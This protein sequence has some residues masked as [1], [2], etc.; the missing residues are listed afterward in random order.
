[1]GAQG[2]GWAAPG[3]AGGSEDRGPQRAPRPWAANALG[4]PRPQP[5]RKPHL[6]LAPG[7]PPRSEPPPAFQ[8]LSGGSEDRGPQRAPRPWAANAL[9][10]PRPQ[11]HRKPHLPLA[12]GTPPRS[13]PPPA[14]Q[15]LSGGSEDRGPQR[16]PRPW[17]ANALGS[18]RPQPHRK[19]HLPLA[20]GT[21]PRSEPPPAFQPLSGGSED[22]GPQRAPR[23]WAANALGSPRP[24]PHRKPH[25]P[26]APGTPPR[27]EPPPA[28]QPLSGGS[29]DRGPQRA[30]RPWAANAL[31][32]P[33]PQPHRK[34]HLPLAPGT[35]PRSEP[36][37]AFQPL[38][39]GSEDRGPQRA[40]RPWAA[41][42]LGSPRPQ[43]HRKPHLPLAPG[44]PP[45]SEPPPAFQ[46][47]SGG[48]EDR[49]PQRAPRPWA[50][51][52]LGSPRPQPH[53]KPHLPLAPGTPPRS[54]PPPAF[55]PLSG[56]SEDRGPQR[57]PRP[58]AANALG[59]PRPQPHRKPHLPLAPGTPPRSEPPPAFQPLSGGSEDRGPQR[60]PRPWAANALGSPRPQPHRKPHLPLAPGTPPRSEPPPAFQPL[61]GGSEDRGPQRAPR[62]WAANALGSP[63][64]QPH[65]KPHLP[66][67]PGTPPR[68]EPPPAFQPLSGGSEDRGPQRAPRPWAAN[69]LGSPRPQPHRKPHLPLAPGTPPRSE[70]PPAFQPLS[71][72][73]ED[74]GPQRAPRPWAANALGSPRPQPHRKPHLPLAPGT[75]PRSEPPPAFQPLSGGSEDRGPQRAPRPWAANA[76]GSP[77]PQPHRKPHL[78]LAPGT[79]PRSEPPP[80]FQPLS[81]GSED[82]GPQRAPRPW[83][84]NALGSPRPQPH[85]KPHLPLAPGTPPRSEP[86]PAF[87]P[88]SGGSEDR[89]PQRAPRPWAANALGSPRPQ[90]HRKPHLP[91]A[92]GTPPRSEPPPAFQPLSGGSED[93][94]PQRAP[95]PWAAN[96]LGSPRPQP[97]RKPHLPLAPGTPPRSEPPPAFQPLSGGSEDRGPQRAPRPWAAN[98][99]GSP[100][101]QPHRKPH[102]P[103]APGTPPRS[104]PPPAFQ[105]LSGGSEDRGPQRA[106]RP[107]AA[108]ALGSPRPQPHRKPHLPLAPG[109]PPRSEPPPAFQPL[110]GGSEDRGPQRA[111]RPWAANALGSPRP[112]P[113]RKPHLPLAPGTP[114]RSEPP[115]AFQPLSGGSEDRGPQR[116]PRP[117][118]ANALGSPRPQPHRKPHLPL[119]PGTPPRSEPPPAFQPLSG[120][121]EDRGPQRAPRPWAANALGSPRPQ[122]HRKPHLPLAPGTPPR[123]E[124]PPA[125]QPLS[126]GSEDRGPQRAPRPWAANALGSPRPQPHRKPHLPLAPGTPPRSEPPPA[127]QPLSGG[128]EDRGPQ[129]AP[130][131]WAANALGSPRPQPHRKPHLPLAPGTPPRSEPPPAFQPLSGG[132]EDR[133]PQ[134][135]PR[136]WAANALGSP[137]PQPHRKPHLPLAP[138]TP[139]RSEPPPAFQ[140]LSG[141]SED[142]G[143][144]RAPRPW[145]ANALGSPRPQ[146]HRKPH[147]PLAPGTPP[148]SEPPPAFQPLSGGSED[149]GP[150]RAPRPWAANA[151]GSPRPQPH[152]KPHLPLAPGT[153]PR[154]EPP[155]AFQPL[156]GGSEDR[157]PQRAPRPWAANAL[158]SPRP[159]PH[160]KPHLPL[161]P[162][163]PPRSEPPPAFQPL[164]GGSEDRGPQRAPRPWA[165]NALG[166]PRPQPHRKP[167]LPLAPGTPPRS[168]PPPA[169]QPLSGGSEDRGPQRAPRPWAANALGSPRPQ[170]HRKPHLPLAPGTPPRSE[171]PPA[172]Q[173]LSGGSEDRGPQRAPRPWA[174]NALGSPRPQPHRKPHLP[175]A[176][177][178]P[179]RSEPPPAFQPLSGGSEDRGPQRAPRPWAANA[180]GSPRPQ[181]HRKPH[182]PLAPGTPPRSE[183]P[184]AF[185]PLS[186]GSEDRGPQRAPRPWAANAL[187]SPRPQPH[188]KPHL[189]LAPGTPPRSEPPPAFQ[190][191]SGGSEDRGPQRAPRPWAANALGSP[192]PQ[193]HRKPHLPLAPGTPPR[194]EPPPAFQ[195]LSGGSEDR[196]PQRAPRPWAANALGSPRPQPHRK[197]HLPLAPGTPPRS[198]PPP[199]FQPLSGGS[200]DRGPQRAPRPWAANALG[201][202]RPQPHRKPH[203]PLAPGTPP[204]SEP[205]PA[206]QPLSGGS[207]DRGPQRAPRPWAANALGSPRPQ[208][209]RKPH[210]PLA[211]GTPPRS[212]PPPAFQPLSGGS[213]DRGPQRAPRPWAANAL[214]SPRPQPHRKPHLPLAPGTP[215]RSEPPPA[216]QPLSG[217]S[218]DRGPQR[219]PRPWAAN[220]LGSP[221]PQPHRKPHL[222][223]APGTPPRSEPPPAF[224]P[225]SGGSE[226]RGPQRAP[227]PWAANAL[228]SPRPQPH[229]KPHLPLAPGT[230]PR[231]EPPPA[232]QPLSGGSEDRGPQRAPRPWAAN[233]LGSPRPQPHRKPHLPLAPG[234]P[235][236]SEPPPAFQPLSG[237]SEDRGPQRAPRPWAANALGSPR[238][239]PHRKPHLPL[240]PGTPPRSEPPPAFQPLSGGSEDRGPQRAPR[241]WAANALGSPRPQPHRKPH[242]PLAPGTPP[243]SEPPP[244]FQPLSGGSEDRGP[245]RAPRPWAAN[246]LGSPRPQPHRKPHLPL[247]PGTP[248]RSEP[249]P[250]FQ[251][252]SGGSEDRGP[253]R[254]PR[255]WA[256]NALGSPRPQPHRKPHLPLA[257]GTPPRSEPPPAF[258]PLSGGSED[259]GPQRAPRPWAANALGS[260]RPQPHRK[261]HLPLAPGTPP[262][263]EPPPAFQ[264]L[265]GGSE[266]RGPQRA[267]RPWAANALGSPRPQPH[268]KPHLPL[269]PGTP[270]RSEPPPAFQP[271]SG[272]SEDRGPQRA[273]R[274]WAANALGSPRP[275]PHRKPHLPLAP[276]T[277]PR[278][279]PP[280]A[281]QPLSGG[282]EDRGP[283]RAPRPWAAN[284]LGSPRPQPH[285]KPHLPLAPGTPPRSE[286]P[287]AFQPLSG[288]SEDRGPQRAP[289]PWAANALGSPRP[290]PHRKPHLPLAPGTPP[291]SEPPPAF[292][293]LSGG[294]EDR[295]PQR[296]PRPWAANALGSPRPQPHRKPH[297]PLAPGTPP[298]SEP[299][300][301]FQPLSGG[302]EDR[303]PQRAPRPWAANAL[304]SPRPQPH[305]KPHLPLAPG[306]PPRSE[307]PPAFQPLSGGSEDRGPQ[308]APRPWAANALGSPRPQPHRKPHLPL[309]PGTPPRSEPPP[310]FQPLSGGSEDRGPQRAPRPWAAN[311]LGSP[312]PQP[313]RKPHLPL[314]PGTPPRSEPPPAFQPLSGGSEDRGPQ[315]APR[316]WAANALGSPRPQ[317]H[318]KPHLPLAPGTPPRSEPPPAFQP[319][320]GGSEDRGPQRAP[321]PWAANAL[322]SPRPQPH[323]KPHLPLAPGTPP[324]SEPP[325]AFQPLSGGSEDRGPQRAPRPWAANALGSPRPQPHRKPH[326]PLAPGTPPRSEPPPAFQPLSG[327]SEDRGPQRAPRPWAANALGSPRP[328]PHRKPHL[329]LAP[330]TPP[331]SEPP[332]AFQPL[333]GG[334]EDRGPQRAPRPWAANALGS[335]RPQPHRKPHLPLAPGTPPRSEPP[336]AF[337]PLS[338]GSEDRGP[339]RAPR[340]W[341]ANALGSPRPQPHRKPHLPL[342][343]GTPPRSEPPPAFQPLS[344]GSEDRGPQRAPRPWA[345]NAL[346]SPRPQPHRKPHLPLAPGTPPRSEPP[347][348]FQPLSGGSEDRGPQR[349]PRPWAANALGSPRPQPHRKPHLPLAPGTPPRSEPPPAFQPLSGGSEDRGP[350][351]APRPWAANAL[352][353][354]RPQPHRKPH[355]PLAPGTPPRSEPPPAFQPLSG[356]SEDRGPQRAPRPWA[357]NALGSPRPQPHRKPHLPLAPGTP[358]RSEPPPAFQPLSGG[359]EDRGPQRA[360]RPWAANALGS[361]RPQPHRKPHLP[362]APGTPP[363]SEPPPAFQPLSGGSE[364]RGPQRAP[365]PW[366]A[367]ALGSP[368]PQPHRKPHLPLAPGTPPRSEPPPAFQPL[369]GGSEDRGPQRAPRPWAANALGSPRPQPH[370][371]PHL[372]LAPGTPP[373]SEPPPAFQPLSGGSEDRGPQRA[374][375]PWA[376]N[377]LGSPR[378]QPHRKPH[379]PLAPGTPPRS[380]PPPAFQP[381]SGG[382][383]DRG[384]QRAPRP[385]AANALGSPRPQPHRKPHLPLAPGTPP[386]SE[387]PPAFQPLSGGSEDRGPQRAPRPWAANALGSPRPQPHRKPH[388][389]LAPGTPPRSEP[390]PAFQPLSGGS[391]DRGPQ[392]A[393]RPWAANALGS[394]RPQPHR[395]PHLPLAP[396]TPPRS[397]PPPAFQPLSGGSEDRGP[398][399][400]P[401]PWAANALGSPRPQPHR[402]P[403]LPLAPGTPPRSE[404][405]P[406]FQPLSGGSED[407]GPQRA[408]R[409][410]A[411]NALGSP[412]PQPHRKPHLPLAPGTPPRSE[413]PP[414]FQPLSG[415]SEDRGPQ[416]A[417]RPWAANALGSPR[418][419]PH[420][421]PHLPLAPGTPPRSEPPPAF[422]PLSG[423]SED[424][425]PQR[426]PRPWAAN[427]LGSPRP[428]PHRKPHLPLAPGTP[429]RSEPPPAFQPLSGGSEDRGPQRAPR[430]WAANALGSPRPQ[431]HRKPHLPLAPGTPPRSEPP[432]AFQPLSGGSEDR[433]PQRAPRPWAAN[434][435]GSPRPQPHR[436]PHLPL[437]PGTPPRSEP[438]PAFQPLSG[439]SEDR[440]PQRAPRPWAANALEEAHP[441]GCSRSRKPCGPPGRAG[442]VLAVGGGAG[443]GRGAACAGSRAAGSP[444]A[445][446][447]AQV[448]RALRAELESCGRRLAR[449]AGGSE[450]RGPQRAPRPWAANALGSPRP[451]PHRKPHLPLAPGTPPRSEPPPAFQPLS[452]GSEDRGPQR[453]PRPWAANA[454]GSPR[455]QPHRKPHLPLAPGTPP[456]SEPPPAFQPLSGGSEDRGPQRAPRPWAANALGSP[457]PQPHRK[458]HL[459]LAPG[460]PPRS[461][462]PPAFQPLSGGSE[463]R[464][465][466]RAPRPWAAN[467]LGSPRPQPHRKPHLPL[468]PGTPPRSEPPP[469]FQPLS[470][471]SEDRG[472]QR[473]GPRPWAANALGSPRPQPHRKPHL[474]LAPGTPP[475]SEPPPAFQPLS[476]GSEDRG[477]Q[478]APRPWAANA[479]GSP[480]P[481]PHRKPH[482]PL[483]PGTPPRSEPPPAFQPLSGGSE[484]RGPQRAPRPWAANALGSPRPQPH[485]KPHLPLA[486]GTPPRSEP[487]PAFQPLSG[488]SEDRGPQRAPRPWA[489]NA[490]GSPRP[491]PHRKPHLPLA[492][493]TP[494]RSEPPPAFQPLSGGSEDRGPQ[495][496]PRPWAANALGSPRPQ[497]HRKPHL[498]LAPGTPPRSEPPPA[499][500]P[501]SGGSEDRGPQ[502]APRP[503]AANAL[504]SPRPQ[505]HRKPHLPLAPGTPPRSEPPP[506]FQPL[507]GGSEDRGPQR[508]PRPWAANALGSPRPQPHR[509][510]HL[511]LAPGTPPR[512]EPPPAFQPLSGGSE[513]RG[514][515]RAPRP[516][517]ANALGSPRPQPH[518]KPHL[519]LAPGTPP[520]SEPPPAFQPLSGGSEDRGPQRA[521][522]PWAANALGSPRPQPHRKPHLPLAPGTP[523]RSEPPPAFQ[524]LSGGSED[525][526][527]QRAPRPWAANALGSPR[528]QPH[529]KPHLPLAP[530]TPPRSEPPPAFQPLSGGSEDRGPQRAPRPWAAN[531]L[532]S[533]RPQPHRK[534]HLPL[535]PG[536]PPRSEPPPAFQPLSGGSEDRGPQ[537][538]PR[539]WAANALGSPRPQPH[540][541]PHLPLAPGTPPRSEP[542]P[543]FQPLSGGSEDRGPQRAPRPWAANALGSPR[544]QPHRKPHLPLAPGTPPRSEPPPAFQPLSGGSEDRG[545]QR[546][547]RP[548]AANA[549]GS[550]RPQPHRKPHLPLAPGTPPRSEP[551][552]AFQPLSGGSEDR[553]PQRAPRP[554]A[555]NA[556][557]SPRP[558]PHRKPH[559]PLAPGTPPRSEPP[560]AFQPLSGGS[561][562]RGPQRAPRPWAANAL[563]SPRP[564]PHRK[565]HLPLAP[566]TPP[567][568]EPPPAFQPLSGGSEDRGPQR[569][570]RPWAANAL[571]SPR[572]QPHRKPHLPLAPG[573]P[574]RSE[575]PPA[576]Q[577]LSGGSE[578]RG[579]QRAPR[580]WAANALGSPRPQPH[581]KPHLP[582]AP[583]TPPR[584]EPP[585]AFQPLSGGSEDRGPQRAP[586]PWAA[587]ALGSPRPQ[588][589]RKPHL[590]LAPGTPPRSEPP[591]AFQPLSGGS[592][593]RGPQRAPR[594]WAA[595][596]LGSPRP[597]PHRKPHLPLAPGT[598]P[599]SEPPPAFQPLSGGSEDRGPQRAPR[600]W[601]ANALGS[602]R[603][604]PHRKPHLPLAPGTP[605]R[606]EPPP[607]FQPLSGGSED[608]GPQRAPR[609]WAANALG[610]PRPQ[611]HR[612]PHLP[613]APGTPP[614]SE[615]PPAF[616]PLSGGSEDRGPQRAPRPWAANALGSPRPQPHRKPHLPLAPGTPPRSEPPP[617]FQP[618]SG[619]S[620]DR[621]PQRAPRP[622]AA[623]ALGS[624]R[625]QPHRKPHLPLAPGT[626][627]RS[628]PPPAFQPLSGGSEDRG[629]QRA[630]RPWA[631]NALGSPRPQPHRKPHLPLAPGTPPRSEPPPAFQPLSGGSEDRGPQRAPRPWA[632][633]AL[634]SPRPQPHRKPHLP[635]APG[636]PPRSEP[637][638]AFQPLSGGSED[639]GPQRAP[640]PWA[641][642][643]LGSPRPQPHRKPHL[644]LAPGTPPRSEPP[645]A[646][647]PLS[648]GS[649]DRGP[650]RAP[651]P[652]AANALGSPRPQPHRKPHLPLAPGTPPRSEPPPAFQPLSGGS[653]D[654]GPQR[655]PR[656]WAANALGSPRPQPHRKPHLPLAP[657]TPPRSEPP[658]AFQPLSGGSEDRGPQRAPRPW[659]ANA[660]GS[661]RPQPHRKPHLPLAPGTPPRSEPPPAFQPLSGGSEDRGPQ[662]A[663]RPWAANALGSPRPQPHRKPHLPLAPGTPPRSEPPPAF[664]PLSGGSEDRGPQRAPRPWA[665]NALGSP[666]PQPHRK[667]HLPLAPG[668]PPRSEPPP[669]FQPLSGGS[670]DRGPQRAPRPWAANALG[671]PRPQPHRKPHLP[672]APGTPPR[673]EPPPAFQPLSG[674]SEDRGPQRAPRPWAANAL[675]S[676]RPQPHRKPHLPLAPGT[677]PRSEPPPAFQPL[678]GGSE[679]RGPQRAPRPWAA[680]ALGSPRPQPHRKPHLPLAPGTPP[681]SEPPPAFQPL[682]GGSED[683]GPQRAPRPWAANALGS[684]RPQPHRKPHLPLA[685]GTPPR[686]EPPPAFQPLSGGSEDRGP[687]RAPRP[688]AANALGSPRPQPHRKPH[689]PLAPGTP[690]R[691]EPPPAFQPLSGGSE[692]R[693]PQRAPRP[694]AANALGSP[695][696]QPHRKPHLPLAPGTPPRSEPPPAFQPLSGGSE[697]RGPQRAPRPWAAN[698]LGSPRP[699]PHR[700]PHLPLAPGTPP[701]SE[702]PPAFQPL[703]G[704]SEDRGPQRAPRPWAANALGSPRPQP[705]R[706][707]HLPLA[708]GTPPRSEPPPAFQPLSGGSE[709]RGP[710]R[711][712]RPWAANAL[713][714][715]R[716]QPHRKPHLPLAPGTP[717]RSEP[718]PAFQ[719]LSGGSE[720]RGPQ[721]AP[722]PWAANALGSPRPQPHRKPHLPLAPGTPPR[723][724]PPPAFQPLSGGSEDRGPQRA[725]RPWAANALGSPRPQPHRKPHL[726]LAPG[727][728]PR[729]EP[730]PAFQPLS[731][732]SEDRGPQRA[733]RPWAANALGSPRPQPH[734]KP[735][736]PLAPGTPPRSEPP[737]AFQPLSGGSE[738]RGPQRAPRPWAANALGSPRPQPHRKPHLPLAPGTPPRSEPPPAFQPLSGG[739]EDRGPQRAPRP[740]AANALGSPRPQ[741][742][743]KPH[744][745]LAPGTPPRSEPPPAFQPLS[746]G[747]EDRGPQ[748]A[749]RPW[750]ANALG[751]PRP[752]P[753]RKPHLPLAPG[754]PPRSEPPP[755][756]QPLSGGS[757]DRGPQR[758]PRP[759]A[760]NALGSPRPQPHRKPHLPLAPG[761]PP[762]SEPPPAFQPLS[763]GSEDRGPQ[764]APRPWAANALGSPRPQPHRKP[765]LPLAPG[766]PPRSEPPPAFQ[767]LSGG[768]EDRGPQRAPRPW[769]ANAL[770]SPRPQPHRKPHLPLA[771]GTPPRS[772]PPPAFQPLSGGF[773]H[774]AGAGQDG[775]SGPRLGCA[776]TQEA[777]RT[778]GPSGPEA[779]GSERLG[780][781]GPVL[782]GRHGGN[783]GAS[784][785]RGAGLTSSGR[786]RWWLQVG[787]GTAQVPG[788]MG[789]QGHGWAAPGPA[790]GSEDRGPQRAPRPWAANALGSPR[791][792]PH[793]KPHLPL[794][795]GTPPRSEPPPASWPSQP[796]RK[797]HLPLAP[798]TPPR[799]EPPPA[800]QP[801]SG[802]SEDRGPQRAPRPWAANALGSPRPQPHRKPH[803]PLAPGTPPRSEPPPAFQPLSGGSEDRGPQRAPR[804]W[805]ANALGSPRPQPHRKPHLPL[806]PGTPPRSEPPPAFQPLSG[807]S[808]DRGPQRA[809][810]PWA[811]NALGSPRPQPHRKP[812][813]PLAP[814]T[815]PRSE[816]P[817]AFQPLSGGSE[818][819]GP[820]RAPRP[821][822]ANA[823]GSPR[824]QPHR[825]PHLP[826]APGTPPRS[827]PPPAFQPLSASLHLAAERGPKETVRPEECAERQ[828]AQPSSRNPRLRCAGCRKCKPLAGQRETQSH[829]QHLVETYLSAG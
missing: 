148:R 656:P 544:P 717:P 56:G 156:S 260:P 536:T 549:L 257:P 371:K 543:A 2:H 380:E 19:P 681:R 154:S 298:R 795:P 238:P 571:G 562:D 132:S 356:G 761:T 824:P 139:P 372:P 264:P 296:A 542:P 818:D 381:L 346:G 629:P 541:K 706:K 565:P 809:P 265:S 623:N 222:P 704:G 256:A 799:S 557:G 231:S 523:P 532:G 444:V 708:P 39:G 682:S 36:P 695:R 311:A 180:L 433:G 293:P 50:A 41:N 119:A 624:P 603:P 800:F 451:Q 131:P 34:P 138:G 300:P 622:W 720:D 382:S 527:P 535:A 173:P 464:G 284:A 550:P 525:R 261:P 125:F 640:R 529:R 172:F 511:P 784:V 458:P 798:G 447:A 524:P 644:P 370:R 733:P 365:R 697:D 9:G 533:P 495:R 723:S 81:G 712:P 647:Q 496:A 439:G 266:D 216:F 749:P 373:R 438:P 15:P 27:S 756:F 190:P 577:P 601:A 347:P 775:R 537:R 513:D 262:R 65:R 564:Q 398:Q 272:G 475:R 242:L 353:S 760:A 383:E 407:R 634:G 722:R 303:G 188:R 490:L 686:S 574:P 460:T 412:R 349:A 241:P 754:T 517:A 468:A 483:A 267:P 72:G 591:P 578:D 292:Q 100:R 226:D 308:R 350:Q 658:P 482:L 498:P 726:P 655:A 637:P 707:P 270:P 387:P 668:T 323:R 493:G 403:H 115:P 31:G 217:G 592:E 610:S 481:Q 442:R 113:H 388:L 569:A 5:H 727:T 522:R 248:P 235:P 558:Q 211:P 287:P 630:P 71:G 181:P 283:Q 808:E 18:P 783:G 22:R 142:R 108:N 643:A 485:R 162:G 77:R 297:L 25:L 67:A 114:P 334:S 21:P 232:F 59:S 199:A 718:P 813:L 670:E 566:G 152:R 472:P 492:P 137:R 110:S 500:Q 779:L 95:R 449:A 153:P 344:G 185:Q 336:P 663:P 158:G 462:P 703:S 684:P 20:P 738:D 406:A 127:F 505:P 405:P 6:P 698:A 547:P 358:P 282:S 627:P 714:S 502:R 555:A 705:H 774:R 28:F 773:G 534:P 609:P 816:P 652:W 254:A 278:S 692:D 140:P 741:P 343:P 805:A 53:R 645:P 184:P 430:P 294:S 179:P 327:G 351:R 24:Q 290:Q 614:R 520:R 801:L 453:A 636:T 638:P 227:R 402:K 521:P 38:S 189:P 731:G 691:S 659:A 161:A 384:P 240:A 92:P 355:L 625:P 409:P 711:A 474:P 538:A 247:A 769:A 3:P 305:R 452:G 399:R 530:G 479:L 201:S 619:G 488:G 224:Q 118:A 539:P 489:A 729:S 12:P 676:P 82:R 477:P 268:R 699:Q 360:P 404:P 178:T 291:R 164:S 470:G 150:Q 531:A 478:R 304:G 259:R 117:W 253:Q 428:Q 765:H 662:R 147:L 429:P 473:A 665:A 687:Q 126:G 753:H 423:G 288:G 182:L 55:Q 819:R 740:W 44:T 194:S 198:E 123:S 480:R 596:A 195:P 600:P 579:P 561:E 408:P 435:L 88:L 437:A 340:P 758:A 526:G 26:L 491:Q 419:Q 249:P 4:S 342:A 63:R 98:A 396:G 335:P 318:R 484:D 333:S 89:G 414:A 736:L 694:W 146:P 324:R 744:L 471:G 341:A 263:S 606:S 32:S 133:G 165:A 487:P 790:G 747:S 812:H 30:P 794:A 690:P 244:A 608:R 210:L 129:R 52:A 286:P 570:P 51:N 815:P 218:E 416:R 735:H 503:W 743:R 250:A 61:S 208:P 732:G 509:K 171:P 73:S 646:F 742:H 499:F 827:E 648:G 454:L 314:A 99:L 642:N 576:F 151:L 563:G 683:R 507:S 737:P 364:D 209:H 721:R 770:G 393:P 679:D 219:A 413:P 310:A 312:R 363:R 820:Q 174:A 394:P 87:Q 701:R 274:P 506:A 516:W 101:P 345:A 427:A 46:P 582:L 8:P 518:R 160:R 771:P 317:P 789:A 605:P 200:E 177:G 750:A 29:E 728:P 719:P 206:F 390:P 519:P 361:P 84:A 575:P 57:A 325:P 716:P 202:P 804:P 548:W 204:R 616:Q 653:E 436:K 467:A 170:P 666:R 271:L 258:Q 107:W 772:E 378:P 49:G 269:A 83:A 197:P 434:A 689:L 326:L 420:R 672:L 441:A 572:P 426:A 252:L 375:R 40:P 450:D 135:A 96:A 163:T 64:P 186:G 767:P 785:G 508:A 223:L 338:G 320:S 245:Q 635:L 607:A 621:G 120:G 306:T 58:W 352:G 11:P 43:P 70:P 651:R 392:R 68:S 777:Q 512:S 295:G 157:G 661:P 803:L 811:A 685:P 339:Q 693:G 768:S 664:Q 7:T 196:G 13:E 515:Q 166:S 401:R 604:Q 752:Q 573:T 725:P 386:R 1:M 810:R 230:P 103:L 595:N 688:W 411:A 281:F 313:H 788:R 825:K 183:P 766:T 673:S 628:E 457:R 764:R 710:Q 593:D 143:P 466:Q 307:P 225:L 17:A 385:W 552:P 448:Q 459:P 168:E 329:P 424:R 709:D 476:G 169:F 734:R 255:P 155:P 69:A 359:S 236:R 589:H 510:P 328:Q 641:A 514:P 715:P 807:G 366:A 14:F 786:R 817:P 787:L 367:N 112:Q 702:P 159:Q 759:W 75:P 585:P 128:S 828:L 792:Q 391:E 796:H 617:A 124:P 322:G 633:N 559:L 746:G 806:A 35:P 677:P 763:G 421:K 486:P 797:P 207:E 776:W 599:R 379:L 54:E 106:P 130:R 560:P 469:A 116:A 121:S 362:L 613:L 654:R 348:A 751:S 105:P 134:R 239:Q 47:L 757:E 631:A 700:K 94:G 556:L 620:E 611:P 213:E 16:A 74:R 214:G 739:S 79:P 781:Q 243:R 279:E 669:A 504:G 568:S 273:P 678:S 102:L 191:L 319:L 221:R 814:G 301:A 598:P 802:G 285:R 377:A 791:P 602:P 111:P 671:S 275:Q 45:R 410:W 149:R 696:P 667:P 583:G 713:G 425:G 584:S 639:R 431:P 612:K 10:S 60:A 755:A 461:E 821:W 354:P 203:L 567:R 48:S 246:A 546:A 187:G 597:Q 192:R 167:H 432:P 93:R 594:P 144:Q 332:P 91:L 78:P 280:P 176:P 400:A 778:A 782:G 554:W 780:E 228:G 455:P 337:Q 42:A 445:G 397:E 389:P 376:A 97:H 233:A 674:G 649:E 440:G 141:G 822:A 277:P 136:P 66:L 730:P 418:P 220:A 748:R 551:P 109:T 369:S 368:R 465:P 229:R 251:P 745:P 122:P 212:E 650:Q 302:S 145:A 586:R 657:G 632:A 588:P 357:A 581:R 215:P 497:P 80:A 415:G 660:L 618:L 422:Q 417:P 675:G 587:N 724:E 615:P 234:T 330:G 395:K 823:L 104:E 205:P 680:N 276:G 826:L 62:P 299:P 793:R 237:G 501:L 33:R 23:P 463:D 316:P 456:R 590:P 540:R 829:H 315:R 528:P 494:P 86:P 76:L 443:A 309:A 374:P 289:R 331:R 553:G 175:L 90:P 193:P 762:R 321:R 580:P 37:P 545:P 85:R 626:P 446:G